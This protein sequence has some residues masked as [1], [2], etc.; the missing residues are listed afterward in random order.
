MSASAAFPV[1]AGVIEPE[2]GSSL[3]SAAMAIGQAAL[4]VLLLLLGVS[5]AWLDGAGV[6]PVALGALVLVVFAVGLG[7]HSQI[8][9]VGRTVW[10]LLTLAGTVALFMLHRDFLWL[11]FPG[12]L[13][14]G[15]VLSLPVA[16]AATGISLA[17]VITVLSYQGQISSAATLGPVIGALVAVG[18]ARGV[19]RLNREATEHRRLL[20]QVMA[21]QRELVALSDEVVRAQRDAGVLAERSRLSRDIH[22]T[23]AQGFSSIVLLARAAER[24]PD[25]ART[26]ALLA[27]IRAT[28]AENLV[29]SRRVVH[30]L[31]PDALDAD[32]LSSPL[33]RMAADLRTALGA[34]VEVRIDPD[35]PRL[36]TSVEVALL[37]SAQGALANVRRHSAATKVTITLGTDG[38]D[39]RLDIVDNGR[40]FDPARVAGPPG[41]D[42][43]YGLTALRQRLRDLG[44]TLAVESEPGGG[45]ALSASVPWRRTEP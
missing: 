27:Q 8:K 17:A 1:P 15:L 34:E 10:V 12:W 40:G 24:E 6:G 39:A 25:P 11:A 32:G 33:R 31:T 20:A 36:P 29:E 9:A 35:L 7:L 16:L 4:F 41:M 42:G 18:I 44:G 5:R 45:T 28:A 30:A 37:R 3:A 21:A 38:D 2:H 22:D 19:R 14:A 26:G 43:G 13:L 23:L